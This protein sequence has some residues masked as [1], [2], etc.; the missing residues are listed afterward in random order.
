MKIICFLSSF[1][2]A[3][4]LLKELKPRPGGIDDEALRHRILGNFLLLATKQKSNIEVA[5]EDFTTLASQ[6]TFKEHIGPILG[7]ASAHTLLKQTQRARNQLKR[8]AK[9]VWTFEDAEYLERCWLLLADIYVQSAKYD[10][11]M[12]LLR[13]VLQ[14]NKTCTKAYEFCGYVAEKEQHYKEA[15]SHYDSAWKY[16]GKGAPAVGYK[17][18][19]CHMKCKKYADAIDVCNQVLKTYPDYPKIKKDIYDKS[20][21]N[22]RT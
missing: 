16:G 6:E 15:A 1:I 8:V 5:L 11:A 19:F 17:L 12:D 10:L 9:S 14:H 21:N 4:R 2:P 7:V 20:L 18:A 13:R 22:L 3:E